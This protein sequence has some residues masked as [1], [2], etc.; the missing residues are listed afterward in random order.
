MPATSWSSAS[1]HTSSARCGR[2]VLGGLGGFGALVRAARRALSRSRCWSPAP[3][4]SAPSCGSRSKPAATTR[5]A[6]TSSPCAPTT[7][8]CK[9]PSRSSFSTTTPPAHLDVEVATSVI[10]GIVEGCVQ[11][12]AALVGGETAEMPGMYHGDDYDLAGF[13]VGIVEKDRIIDGSRTRAGDAI[14]GLPSS[15]PHSNGY[16]LIR[17][18][19][20][21]AGAGRRHAARRRARCTTPARA[22]T[23][24]RQT[25]AG[26]ARGGAGA[27][28]RAHHRRRP[29][30]EHSARRSRRP[31]SR[32]RAQ[33]AGH[34]IRCSTGCSTTG[35]IADTEMYR[36]FNCGI[37]MTVCVPAEHVESAL[38][39]LR[40]PANRR[41]SSA[42]SRAGRVAWSSRHDRRGARRCRSSS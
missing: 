34:A 8:S 20:A 23:H 40:Q 21:V 4:A 42:K 18:L 26:A 6:S 27:R 32:A 22:D 12:G 41:C 38:Q 15:G 3:T 7:S 14:I 39:R 37:G 2:E 30:R 5:S 31:R 36:T 29:A 11:A 16:S 13:C 24:L 25:P 17:K 19:I 10:K 35:N 1:S 28:H 9:A 33:R